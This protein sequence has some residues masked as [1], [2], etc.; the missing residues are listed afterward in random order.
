MPQ[1]LS[2]VIVHLVFSTKD[3]RPWLEDRYLRERLHAELGGIS[4][5]LDCPPLIVG[6]VEDH[7]HLL[8]R[9]SRTIAL[10]DW[11]KELKRV[12]SLWMK[13]QGA[14]FQSFAWQAGYGAFSVSQSNIGQV[15]E[16]IQRQEEHHQKQDFRSEFLELLKR[17]QI[18]YNERYL[19]D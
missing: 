11:L 4:K 12:S 1:S 6:G 18:E 16:Y 7:I 3:R 17:H 2:N 10:S 9:M 5:A 15:T 13:D 19:W 14:N 8:A